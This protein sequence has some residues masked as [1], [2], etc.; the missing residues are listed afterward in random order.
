M[1]EVD[2]SIN[3]G[4]LK[5]N[6]PVMTASGTFGYGLEFEDVLDLS[7]IGALVVKGLSLKPRV[8]NPQP[9]IAETAGGMLNSI[10]LQN[11]GAEAFIKD[12]LPRLKELGATV[13]ANVF[14]ETF[15]EYRNLGELLA[16]EADIAG[17]EL[18]LSCPHVEKGGMHFGTD[19]KTVRE[20]TAAVRRS[21]PKRLLM[22]KLTP[23]VTDICAIARAAKEGG[24]DAVSCINTLKG[25]A[26]DIETGRPRLGTVVGGL[27]GPAIKPVALALVH[28]VVRE[29]EIPV[30][31]V[32][33]IMNTNDALEF[34]IVGAQA[35]QVGTA[36]YVDAA[37]S[38]K[39]V[40]GLREELLRRKLKSVNQLIGTLCLPTG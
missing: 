22:V 8:G 24:A 35:V 11:V 12:K 39:L 26:V 14:G 19:P 29:V 36:N 17:I 15:E 40:R 18:N 9:R 27:S 6:N 38:A 28:Q 30:V 10:G 37:I 1:S 7:E 13:I 23:N 32:G 34:L 33:G 31:G 5:L 4:P 16:G 20:L 3:L 21:Y 25:M 2:L